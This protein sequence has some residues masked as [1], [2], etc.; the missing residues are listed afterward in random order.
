MG[1]ITI[2]EFTNKEVKPWQLI[3]FTNGLISMYRDDTYARIKVS[4]VIDH[5][6]V[7]SINDY[8]AK[9]AKQSNMYYYDFK[10]CT[11]LESNRKTLIPDVAYYENNSNNEKHMLL[12]T[13]C[14]PYKVIG[15]SYNEFRVRPVYTFKLNNHGG[16]GELVGISNRLDGFVMSLTLV[17]DVVEEIT[18]TIHNKEISY[19]SNK[20][21]DQRRR[22]ELPL[23]FRIH[24]TSVLTNNIICGNG[25]KCKVISIISN[26][27]KFFKGMEIHEVHK[28]TQ[29][30]KELLEK[31]NN[32][33]VKAI[34]IY[35]S[36]Y[37]DRS[38]LNRY[39]INFVFRLNDD[40][41]VINIKAE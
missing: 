29:K 24:C 13:V 3:C 7:S 33:G 41:S 38:L 21:L 36:V 10:H 22:F 8:F 4:R 40:G 27:Q 18:F 9:C 11:A 25:E 26:T 31:L 23:Y 28:D 12:I 39:H 30:I 35:G 17:S 37:M 16:V 6:D 5:G 15:Y 32:N 14:E 1:R 2:V 34:T 19:T 20:K